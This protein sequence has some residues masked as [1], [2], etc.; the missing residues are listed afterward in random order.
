MSP[1]PTA[2]PTNVY[3]IKTYFKNVRYQLVIMICEYVQVILGDT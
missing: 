1:R 3:Y 2:L